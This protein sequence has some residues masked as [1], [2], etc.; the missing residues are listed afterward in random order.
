MFLVDLIYAHANEGLHAEMLRRYMPKTASRELD[1]LYSR[2]GS[3][4]R[5]VIWDERKK[6]ATPVPDRNRVD[7]PIKRATAKIIPWRSRPLQP[8]DSKKWITTC[9]DQ[10]FWCP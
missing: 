10:G 4:Y 2:F 9:I 3:I 8:S 1:E 6:A 5:D 7:W